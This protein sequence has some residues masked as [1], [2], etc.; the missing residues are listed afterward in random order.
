[1]SGTTTYNVPIYCGAAITTQHKANLYARSIEKAGHRAYIYCKGKFLAPRKSLVQEFSQVSEMID[2]S[3]MDLSIRSHDDDYMPMGFICNDWIFNEVNFR[4]N[5]LPGQSY[6]FDISD[7]SNIDKV[8][9]NTNLDY[10]RTW[11]NLEEVP[12]DIAIYIKPSHGSGTSGGNPWSYTRHDSKKEFLKFLS[13][14]GLLDA[15]SNYQMRPGLLG[16]Y[17]I[18]EYI[19]T[20]NVIYHHYL[21]DQFKSQGNHG[22]QWMSGAMRMNSNHT[23]TYMRCRVDSEDTFNF[24]S[25]MSAPIMSAIQAVQN[26]G[27]MK[28]FDFNVRSSGVW[29][30]IHKFICPTFFDTY[31]DNL[32][33]K[34]QNSYKFDFTEFEYSVNRDEVELDN[35]VEIPMDDYPQAGQKNTI[36]M[37]MK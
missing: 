9:E 31:F 33:N 12:N 7:K 8:V 19:D 35:V 24:A 25:K 15:F 3:L 20:S 22:R 1:M 32:L 36:Y 5:S 34:V 18:Q 30:Y 13:H 6:A 16:A 14:Q 10:V 26:N 28:V 11:L 37:G 4:V 2:K 17:V 21:N 23:C 29:A 27:R